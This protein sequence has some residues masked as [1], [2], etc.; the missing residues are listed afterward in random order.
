MKDDSVWENVKQAITKPGRHLFAVGRIEPRREWVPLSPDVEYRI[1]CKH[2][3]WL[4]AMRRP[5]DNGFL[6]PAA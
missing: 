6:P 3:R 1:L 5:D 4:D 2:A